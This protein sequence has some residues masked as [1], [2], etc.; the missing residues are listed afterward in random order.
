M[1]SLKRKC[2]AE[3]L[4]DIVR[5]ARACGPERRIGLMTGG[6]ELG[7]EELLRGARMAREARPNLRVLAIGTPVPGWE[8]LDWIPCGDSDGAR[9]AALDTAFSEGRI[10][11]AVALHYPFPIGVTTVGRILTPGRGMPLFVASCTGMSHAR[12]GPAL[13]LNA[14]YGLAVAKAA[15]LERPSL[16]FL[17]LDGAAQALRALQR[18]R[19]AGYDVVLGGSGRSDGGNLLRGNDLVAGSVDVL[20]CDSL[21]GNALVKVFASFASGGYRE[22]AGW[23]YGPSAGEGWNRVV[24]II[25]RASGAPVV[26]QA[27]QLAA[28][29]AAARLPDIVARELDSARAAGLDDALAQLMPAAS[30]AVASAPV[31]PPAVPVDAQI[32]GVDVLD[33]EAATQALWKENIYAENAMGCTGPVIRVQ[34]SLREKAAV[35]LQREG[36]LAPSEGDPQ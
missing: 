26:A 35:I 1:D 16:A 23:G 34:A 5:T 30:A 15:G 18:L 12:R 36:F 17:N 21:T 25:S 6:G 8:D 9:A 32:P 11:G 3:A 20:V 2:I 4:A 19:D 22:T 10:D 31:A 7:A 33:L 24:S 14:V 29:C 27:L 13:L 28:T